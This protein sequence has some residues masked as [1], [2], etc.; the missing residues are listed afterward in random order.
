MSLIESM[1][2][3][4]KD[5]KGFVNGS[6]FCHSGWVIP[7]ELRVELKTPVEHKVGTYFVIL[8]PSKVHE[9]QLPNNSW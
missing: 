4:S 8:R 6:R 7:G 9:V 3:L 1:Y 5:T 2:D